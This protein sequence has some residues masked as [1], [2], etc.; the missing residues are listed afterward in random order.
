[1]LQ[2]TL[3][4]F[5][6][7]VLL[8]VQSV[9]GE[10]L[11]PAD[12]N[13]A[14]VPSDAWENFF[15]YYSRFLTQRLH[16]P[17]R[18]RHNEERKAVE[19]R[20]NH[21][22]LAVLFEKLS[23]SCQKFAASENFPPFADPKRERLERDK[24][25]GTWCFYKN[26]PPNQ[27]DIRQEAYYL[28][29]LSLLHTAEADKNFTPLNDYAGQIAASPPFVL[30]YQEIKRT[31]YRKNLDRLS[32]GGIEAD[33]NVFADL[34]R[35]YQTFLPAHFN[36]RNLETLE[37]ILQTAEK[38][39]KSRSSEMVTLLTHLTAAASQSANKQAAA[40]VKGAAELVDLTAVYEGTLRRL[41]LSGKP[42]PIWGIDQTGA[43]FDEKTLENKVVLLDFWATWC[44]PCIAEFPHLKT[45]YAKYHDRGFE[46][47]GYN[48][49]SEEPQWT[50][51]LQKRPLPW[52]VL[53]KQKSVEKGELPL[54]TYYGVKTLPVVILRDRQ[55]NA[56]LLDARGR[57]L[58]EALE[59][60]FE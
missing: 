17:L 7:M 33:W 30:L 29:Y 40:S 2:K 38:Y 24:I 22:E 42:V 5:C 11:P 4:F 34:V 8:Q 52:T 60:M 16:R 27:A 51:F 10:T 37:R 59:R 39:E 9:Q 43:V 18:E 19:E 58:D 13:A 20:R 45:L 3:F 57:K 14:E 49:D 28:R 35:D 56:V 53:V 25:P 55:G 50:A 12:W 32:K 21:Q 31:W 44:S 48:V 15:N 36:K 1:M 54:S 23:E 46:I 41:E 47:I 6:L 26:V